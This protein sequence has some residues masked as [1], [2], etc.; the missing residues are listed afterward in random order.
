[1]VEGTAA[2]SYIFSDGQD[3]AAMMSPKNKKTFDL[4]YSSDVDMSTIE[5]VSAH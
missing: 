1:M 2:K 4:A 3:Y 5:K